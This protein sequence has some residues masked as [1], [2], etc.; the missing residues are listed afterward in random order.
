MVGA[1][2]RWGGRILA[3]TN[4][5]ERTCF[6]VL[7][8]PLDSRA[9][10]RPGDEVAGRF[11]V[12]APGFY[13]PEVFATGRSITVIG[14]VERE[15]FQRIDSL[16]LP[17]PIVSAEAVHLWPQRRVVY[18]YPPPGWG[19]GGWGPY[20]GYYGW[21]PYP[22][23]PGYPYYWGPGYP[24]YWG[25]GYRYYGGPIIIGPRA[26][27]P[28][29]HAPGRGMRGGARPPMRAAPGARVPVGAR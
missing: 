8:L 12:C 24:Y 9:R 19:W 1:Q 23:G 11:R 17:L 7:A 13:D 4:E 25:P 3:T 27:R 18:S 26:G 20:G 16:E 21:G 22:W 28:I 5:A 29:G 2:V 6:D 10:P 14:T 15:T